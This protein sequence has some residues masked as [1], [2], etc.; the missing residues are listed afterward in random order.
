M[1]DFMSADLG[2][3]ARV[4]QYIFNGYERNSLAA[5]YRMVQTNE[6]SWREKRRNRQI[7]ELRAKSGGF[8]MGGSGFG[9][10]Q[11]MVHESSPG[12]MMKPAERIAQ[13][14]DMLDKG[15]ISDSEFE[16]IKARIVSEL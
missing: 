7:E 5:V 12:V 3:N 2:P 13:A 10:S 11:S 16:T 1:P 14:R 15:L 9:G 6:Q 4:L 8:Q